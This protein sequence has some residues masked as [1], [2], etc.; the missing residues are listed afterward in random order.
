MY[1]ANIPIIYCIPIVFIH[2]SALR[3]WKDKFKRNWGMNVRN[4]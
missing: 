3:N 2:L 1:K 4:K